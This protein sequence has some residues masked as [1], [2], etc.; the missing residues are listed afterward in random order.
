MRHAAIINVEVRIEQCLAL[1]PQIIGLRFQPFA[2]FLFFGV[3]GQTVLQIADDLLILRGDI[4]LL[5]GICGQVEQFSLAGQ[6]RDLHQF[7]VALDDRSTKC[8]YVPQDVVMR[9]GF[10]LGNRCPDVLAVERI[11]P[12]SSFCFW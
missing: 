6:Q 11:F 5:A 2:N 12:R 10:T 7:Q 9:R 4:G 1:C 8:L 3:R